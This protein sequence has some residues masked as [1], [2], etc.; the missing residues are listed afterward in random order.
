M[1][2]MARDGLQFVLPLVALALIGFGLGWPWL[3]WPALA[4]GAF[5]AFFFRDPERLPPAVS[6][7]VLAP[8]DGRVVEVVP[9]TEWQGAEGEPLTRVGIFLSP[10]DVHINRAP[11]AGTV[12]QIQLTASPLAL[13]SVPQVDAASFN[14]LK[15]DVVYDGPAAKL[16]MRSGAF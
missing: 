1:L 8:A 11:A 2:G 10:L 13:T 7:A 14:D 3:A 12:A 16:K 6:E 4:A 9:F 15:M 5:M